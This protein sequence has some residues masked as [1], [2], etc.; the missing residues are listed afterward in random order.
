MGIAEKSVR[1]AVWKR[2]WHKKGFE[3]GLW[4]LVPGKGVDTQK[5]WL[6]LRTQEL[7]VNA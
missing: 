1:R 6:D 4:G 7:A 3:F 5:A 2:R